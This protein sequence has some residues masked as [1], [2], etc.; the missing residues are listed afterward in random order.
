MTFILNSWTNFTCV[1][2]KYIYEIK[3]S[4][5]FMLTRKV[6]D[7]KVL[8]LIP[9]QPTGAFV[10]AR[11]SPCSEDGSSNSTTRP[12][13]NQIFSGGNKR[14]CFLLSLLAGT[15]RHPL[16]SYLVLKSNNLLSLQSLKRRPS[17]K[18]IDSNVDSPCVVV[19]IA[20]LATERSVSTASFR[21]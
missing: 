9:F 1:S 20:S 4:V 16:C 12:G 2:D 18:E 10:T 15:K 5:F 11:K 17:V 6:T 7:C 14:S 3:Q 8:L 13:S 21:V 19:I